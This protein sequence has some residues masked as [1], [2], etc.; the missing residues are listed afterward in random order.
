MAWA[1]T[2]S[3]EAESLR[4]P[5]IALLPVDGS[6]AQQ[7]LL[8]QD[9]EP[10]ACWRVCA[11]ALAVPG[12]GRTGLGEVWLDGEGSGR[13]R[14]PAVPGDVRLRLWQPGV[15]SS[16][17]LGPGLTVQGRRMGQSEAAAIA[18]PPQEGRMVITE[19]MKDPQAVSDT[20]GEWIELFNPWWMRQNIEGWTLSDDGGAATVLNN[21][22]A[23]I[24]VAGR[25]HRALVR[26]LDVA[27][28]GGIANAYRYTGFT[29]SNGADQII[30]ALPD[31]TVVDRVA[32][33]DGVL[34]PDASGVA[35]QLDSWLESAIGNDQPHMWCPAQVSYGMGDMGT[36]GEENSDC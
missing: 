11:E 17:W 33:D 14:L 29:L 1:Q 13:L 32:Y 8:V 4:V 5:V 21:G 27:A 26:N 3:V 15:A 18:I 36:P 25:G 16:W 10:G 6:G 24:W 31:G 23:G 30:L 35:A 2:P 9:G 12:A 22:G 20:Q 34:W 28:N 19:F 7:E